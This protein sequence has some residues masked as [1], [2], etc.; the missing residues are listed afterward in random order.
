VTSEVGIVHAHLS[1]VASED[2]AL[3][4]VLELERESP[5]IALE[6]L[7]LLTPRESEVATLVVDGLADREIAARLCLSHHTVSQYVKRIY[8][9]L[10][11][12]SRVGLTRQLLG[13]RRSVRR[14]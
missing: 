4:A 1:A 9:K 12:D 10:G 8:R 7:A 5:A 13:A 6:A 11:V 3:V 2:E 14:S